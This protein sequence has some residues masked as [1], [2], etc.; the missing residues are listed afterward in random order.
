MSPLTFIQKRKRLEKFS[1]MA[2]S[3]RTEIFAH[4]LRRACWSEAKCL[5]GLAQALA[6]KMAQTE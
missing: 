4:S 1:V 5:W 3:S 2:R 6:S